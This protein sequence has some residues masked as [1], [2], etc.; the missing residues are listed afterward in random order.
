MRDNGFMNSCLRLLALKKTDMLHQSTV[1]I[2]LICYCLLTDNLDFVNDVNTSRRG[3]IC[4]LSRAS[5]A[6]N[7][8]Y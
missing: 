2:N 5:G 6:L 7:K 4:L 8:Y 1:G 3:G